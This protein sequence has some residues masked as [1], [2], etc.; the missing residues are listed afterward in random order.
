MVYLFGPNFDNLFE[1]GFNKYLDVNMKLLSFLF[2]ISLFTETIPQSRQMIDTVGRNILKQRD[3]KYDQIIYLRTNYNSFDYESM[4]THL[5]HPNYDIQISTG[6]GRHL[7]FE[8]LNNDSLLDIIGNSG[9]FENLQIGFLEQVPGGIPLFQN[10]SNFPGSNSCTEKII[11]IN[12]DNENEI[13]IRSDNE[14]VNV[15]TNEIDLIKRFPIGRPFNQNTLSADLDENNQVDFIADQYL[16]SKYSLNF[17]E[18][19]YAND[20]LNTITKL[21]SLMYRFF[22]ANGDTVDTLLSTFGD[23]SDFVYGD[24]DDDGLVE[25][26][27]GHTSGFLNIFEKTTSGYRQ[28]FFDNLN[29]W[30]MYQIAITNDINQNGKKEIIVMGNYDGMPIYWLEASGKDKYSVIRKDFIDYGNI[31]I[32][33]LTMYAKDVDMDGKDELVF[34]GGS[35]IWIFK[36]NPVENKWD[37]LLYFNMNHDYDA[38]WGNGHN[39][40]FPGLIA[41]IE[42]NDIDNDGDNDMF[43]STRSQDVTLIFKSTQIVSDVTILNNDYLNTFKFSQ[44]YPNP[45]NPTTSFEYYVPKTSFI[46]ITLYDILGNK[47]KTLVS[48]EMNSGNYTLTVDGSNI[49]SGVYFCTLKSDN[50]TDTK[51]I[52]LL[53]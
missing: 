9:F 5:S 34:Y 41:N 35:L 37:M 19:D 50:F 20:T 13:L 23:F 12:N 28:E 44:N 21:D 36:F 32:Y 30:N 33:P 2:I 29:T 24:I 42:F 6:E 4:F 10:I 52:T 14:F 31:S 48:G 18:Y 8:D 22:T 11:D 15:F 45:F 40:S 53:K 43:I 27:C 7:L 17:Y 3:V 38:M 1:K 26:A 46:T 16:N 47:I 25:V 39:R 49:T 51:K